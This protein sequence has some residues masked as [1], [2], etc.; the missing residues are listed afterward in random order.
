MQYGAYDEGVGTRGTAF[1]VARTEVHTLIK[2]NGRDRCALAFACRW[3]AHHKGPLVL[4]FPRFITLHPRH[5]GS[6]TQNCC[7][8]LDH[9]LNIWSP[10]SSPI[11][12]L[13]ARLHPATTSKLPSGMCLRACCL[14]PL[15]A[16]CSLGDRNTTTPSHS[17]TRGQPLPRMYIALP[18]C[19]D[20]LRLSRHPPVPAPSPPC[21]RYGPVS[22][23]RAVW[24]G[25]VTRV[26]SL[27][28]GSLL[29]QARH[30][31]R[32]VCEGT[33]LQCRYRP[34]MG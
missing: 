1:R 26:Q 16:R 27:G 21:P 28:S 34:L 24:L 19:R 23:A 30:R 3:D 2:G 33:C 25:W 7:F 6:S 5:R 32:G 17:S 20:P 31:P 10:F 22:L 4:F 29:P 15:P 18:H 12:I 9:I 13:V 14:H 11:P 8:S